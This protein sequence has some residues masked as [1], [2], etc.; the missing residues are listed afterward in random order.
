MGKRY[1]GF[2]FDVSPLAGQ[3]G[4]FYKTRKGWKY[5]GIPFPFCVPAVLF[6]LILSNDDFLLYVPEKTK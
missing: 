1:W 4:L 2:N 6:W 3:F 5:F